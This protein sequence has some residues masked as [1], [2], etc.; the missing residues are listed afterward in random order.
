MFKISRKFP[1]FFFNSGNVLEMRCSMNKS[2]TITHPWSYVLRAEVPGSKNNNIIKRVFEICEKQNPLWKWG[3][4]WVTSRIKW[5]FFLF[6]CLGL[7]S[8]EA[9]LDPEGLNCLAYS[10]ITWKK[11]KENFEIFTDIN[12]KVWEKECLVAFD[13]IKS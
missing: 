10:S 3:E 13:K 4:N 11:R 6:C 5:C 8:T 1:H 9:A 2:R 7:S 12:Q